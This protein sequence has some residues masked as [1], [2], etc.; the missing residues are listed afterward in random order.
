MTVTL[1]LFTPALSYYLTPLQLNLALTYASRT[2]H[3]TLA[4]NIS[5]LLSN[6][7]REKFGEENED[8]SDFESETDVVYMENRSSALRQRVQS[9]NGARNGTTGSKM[10]GSSLRIK[11]VTSNIKFDHRS[12]RQPSGSRFL[13]NAH[14]QTTRK[15]NSKEPEEDGEGEG[16]EKEEGVGEEREG[17]GEAVNEM[18]KE[19]FSDEGEEEEEERGSEGEGTPLSTPL[20]GTKKP[21]PFKVSGLHYIIMVSLHGPCVKRVSTIFCCRVVKYL[22]FNFLSDDNA[23]V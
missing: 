18:T 4:R 2:Q 8:L 16:E 1:T 7:G 22:F 17:V 20:P 9:G 3:H 15:A 19:L 11:P 23:R 14:Q 12:E 13:N 5:D 6:L 21:N 10:V